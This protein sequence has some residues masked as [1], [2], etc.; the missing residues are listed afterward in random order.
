MI[1]PD[2]VRHLALLLVAF[3]A[4][5]VIGLLWGVALSDRRKGEP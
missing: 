1:E 2:L 5:T 4:G 3:M